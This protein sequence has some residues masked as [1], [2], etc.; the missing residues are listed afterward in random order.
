MKP[1]QYSIV[2]ITSRRVTGVSL[3]AMLRKGCEIVGFGFFQHN[4]ACQQNNYFSK[5]IFSLIMIYNLI[6]KLF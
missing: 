2:K 6:F 5:K 1:T 3:P 4:F